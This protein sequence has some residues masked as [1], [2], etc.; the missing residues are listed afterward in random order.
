MNQEGGARI[1]ET[2]QR[3]RSHTPESTGELISAGVLSRGKIRG[4]FDIRIGYRVIE[5]P[6]HNGVRIGIHFGEP[7]I[8][9]R[10]LERVSYSENNDGNGQESYTTFY[11][12]GDQRIYTPTTIRRAPFGLGDRI[13]RHGIHADADHWVPYTGVPDWRRSF[14]FSGWSHDPVLPDRSGSRLTTV[15]ASWDLVFP[16]GPPIVDAGTDDGHRGRSVVRRLVYRYRD[17]GAHTVTRDFGDLWHV[18]TRATHA[19]ADNGATPPR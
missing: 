13:D 18:D 8:E 9:Q 4:D 7:G 12:G 3:L 17:T 14:G 5:W 19:Y 6:P 15:V 11:Y 16:E 10:I 2:N 1:A